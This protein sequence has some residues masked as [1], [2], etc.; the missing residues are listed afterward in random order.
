MKPESHNRLIAIL[1][2]VH[3]FVAAAS[4]LGFL[5]SVA[6]LVGFKAAL[7][8]WMF[9]VGN[10]GSDPEFWIYVF[11]ILAVAVYVFF[12]LLFTVP[13]IVGGYGMLRRKR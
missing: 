13:A 12:A 5:L 1:H 8:R 10:T 2:L 6:L 4:A 11:A 7:E 9:P 3:G